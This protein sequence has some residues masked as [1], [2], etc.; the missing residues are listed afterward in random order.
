MKAKIF[1]G[2]PRTGKTRTCDL[3][4]KIENSIYIL[5]KGLKAKDIID[6]IHELQ[7]LNKTLISATELQ[8]IIDDVPKDFD[9]S[10]FFQMLGVSSFK[11]IFTSNHLPEQIGEASFDV[12][13]PVLMFPN[14]EH[15]NKVE[16]MGLVTINNW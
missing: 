10:E 2:E 3:L 14:G 12:R 16:G 9:Y 5:A 7:L 4:V 15:L 13:F 8:I 1:V 11:L 6:I